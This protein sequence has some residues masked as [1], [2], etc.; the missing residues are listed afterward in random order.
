MLSNKIDEETQR[1]PIIHLKGNDIEMALTQSNQYGEEYYS[2][3]TG[4]YTTQGGTHLAAFREASVKTG[5]DFFK[6]EYD[7]SDIRQSVVSA[8]S[9]RVQEPV[10]E[11]HT[12]TKLGSQSV[13][14]EATTVPTFMTYFLKF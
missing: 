10:F 2:F 14:H 9:I 6:K 1:Y 5:R 12:Q 3:V 4:Q 8:I 13:G 11:F 7:S